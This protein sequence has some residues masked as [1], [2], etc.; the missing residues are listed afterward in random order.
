M[1]G[2]AS[3]TLPHVLVIGGCG[4][5]GSHIVHALL[6]HPSRPTVSV[7]SRSPTRNL[8]DGANYHAGD[9][10][11]QSAFEAILSTLRPTI[12]INAASPLAK[13]GGQASAATTIAG[14][15]L[16]L[17]C[18]AE[19]PS[20]KDY[21]YISS[22]S[23]VTGAPF[24]L[25]TESTATL[26]DPAS[27]HDPY[28]AAKATAD[29]MVLT[30]NHPPQ[31]R[32]A[33][34]R[35]SG[36]IGERDTQVIPG[37]LTALGQGMA[38]IQLGDGKSKFEFVYAGNVADACVCCAEAM[39]RETEQEEASEMEGG[40][41][42]QKVAGEAFFITNGEPIEFWGFA[43]LVW[44]L[45]GD[46]TP[47]EKI[48][49]VPMWLAF[50]VAWMAEWTVWALSAGTKRPEKFNKSQM[51]NCSL[52]RTFD[53]TKAKERLRWEPK[54]SLEEGARRGV[55]WAVKNRAERRGKK[56]A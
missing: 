29:T 52:D 43:R 31:L 50:F 39:V 45:A 37:L 22:S 17:A 7:V 35:P 46:R 1:A 24:S 23:I 11:K 30:A 12:I 36:I 34:L 54:V 55:E 10:S 32:T 5:L 18:A 44:R 38:R 3:P 42:G 16:S 2:V 20:V 28:S 6:E 40:P 53:I 25:L 27:H 48:I 47:R 21:I 49:V 13:A 4:F 9:I 8:V 51:E 15:R 41:Q 33:V 19:C 56:S 14:T 26:I